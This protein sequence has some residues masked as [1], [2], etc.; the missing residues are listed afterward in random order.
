MMSPRDDRDWIYEDMIR[1]RESVDGG[2]R[3]WWN[4][5]VNSLVA[6]LRLRISSPEKY[7]HIHSKELSGNQ[8]RSA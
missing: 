1:E 2:F 6:K 4:G 3:Y 8:D 7:T 5:I